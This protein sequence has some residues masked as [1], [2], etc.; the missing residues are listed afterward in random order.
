VTFHDGG[1]VR[2]D[3]VTDN[4]AKKKTLISGGHSE[5]DANFTVLDWSIM[6]VLPVKVART[7]IVSFVDGRIGPTNP[8]WF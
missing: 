4:H 1:N 2:G 3:R 7:G 6:P 8:V 5:N